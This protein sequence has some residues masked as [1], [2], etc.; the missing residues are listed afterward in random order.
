MYGRRESDNEQWKILRVMV[1]Q[2]IQN[3]KYQMSFKKMQMSKWFHKNFNN[4]PKYKKV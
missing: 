1:I 4:T 2:K 3:R